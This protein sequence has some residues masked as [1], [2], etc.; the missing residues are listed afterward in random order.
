MNRF[1]SRYLHNWRVH[2]S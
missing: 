1:G 2:L